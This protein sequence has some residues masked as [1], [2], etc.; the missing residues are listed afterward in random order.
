VIETKDKAPKGAGNK[1]L[2]GILI[3]L[4]G[5]GLLPTRKDPTRA[6]E[7]ARAHELA[8]APR[9]ASRSRRAHR[10]SPH[11]GGSLTELIELAQRW[12]C[13]GQFGLGSFFGEVGTRRDVGNE[14]GAD[15][16]VAGSYV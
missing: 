16:G 2:C 3:K 14:S 8:G 9:G 7:L 10:K 4:L 13:R 12:N 6:R 1:S 11:L 5:S 15:G